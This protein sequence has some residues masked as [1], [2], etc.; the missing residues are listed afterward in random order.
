MMAAEKSREMRRTKI[1]CTIGPASE[2][3]EVL[4]RLI[5]AGMD[6]ARLNFAHGTL[7][8]HARVIERI[9]SLEAKLGKPVAILQDLPGPK[10]RLG[11]FEGGA[12]LLRTGAEFV[13][14]SQP[15]LGTAELAH[16]PSP[17]FFREVRVGDKLLADDGLIELKVLTS[18]GVEVRCQVL[19]GGILRNH[20]GI[21]LPSG[22]MHRAAL[23]KKDLENLEFG[24]AQRVDFVATSFVRG[25]SDLIEVGNFLGAW[26]AKIPIIAKLEKPEAIRNLEEILQLAS[27]VMVARGDLAVEMSI[28]EVPVLQKF[29]LR[30]GRRHKVPVIIATQM[31]ES[32]VEHPRPTRAEASDVANAILDGTDA[33]MLSAETATGRY[34]VEAVEMMVRIALKAEP[35][36]R[37]QPLPQ[38]DEKGFPVVA[39]DTACRAARSLHAKA[40]V[41][42]TESG[43]TARLIS[44]DRPEVPVLAL[45]PWEESRRR[46]ALYWGVVPM[47]IQR[48]ETLEEMS[49]EMEEVLLAAGWVTAGDTLVILSGTPMWKPGTVNAIKLHRVGEMW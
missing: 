15:L 17:D 27:G 23:T 10:I 4:E 5:L 25:A 3:E 24:I 2:S 9:R 39:S 32:M 1:V 43:H 42:F 18:N 22:R 47:L 16:A 14:T 13:I 44:Q 21:G 7:E 30:Q 36:L 29:I 19:T 46:M 12:A 11:D 34:P 41:V 49:H 20:K 28:E 45:T 8:E 35:Y 48:R 38:G 37:L 40:V 31:L 26:G 33:V 6:V